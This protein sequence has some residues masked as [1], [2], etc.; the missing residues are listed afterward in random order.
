MNS[1]SSVSQRELVW[2]QLDKFG[3]IEGESVEDVISRAFLYGLPRSKTWDYRVAVIMG[4][5]NH[6]TTETKYVISLVNE[7]VQED[8]QRSQNHANT[9]SPMSNYQKAVATAPNA[10]QFPSPS[11]VAAASSDVKAP[12]SIGSHPDEVAK[13]APHAQ[14]QTQPDKPRS[15]IDT[16]NYLLCTKPCRNRVAQLRALNSK[17]MDDY[18]SVT[19]KY[20]SLRE[21]NKILYEKIEALKKDIAQLHRDVNQQQCWVHDYKH[22]LTV[23]TLECD[24]VKESVT[25]EEQSAADDNSHSNVA[26]VADCKDCQKC[27]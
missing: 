11:P 10:A 27:P 3:Y 24:S 21:N 12:Q 6:S 17:I 2:K 15:L 14:V 5:Y 13:L 7:Y 4:T 26:D 18:N 23:R 20:I 22:R 19:T 8:K 16:V 9:S 1:P 25:V